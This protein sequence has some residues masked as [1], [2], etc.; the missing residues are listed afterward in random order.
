[1]YIGANVNWEAGEGIV[2]GMGTPYASVG[3][4]LGDFAC[5]ECVALIASEFPDFMEMSPHSLN[6]FLYP[7]G[8]SI[9]STVL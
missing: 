2:T 7:D 6:E 5:V 1:V 3:V 4:L 9:S 8:S